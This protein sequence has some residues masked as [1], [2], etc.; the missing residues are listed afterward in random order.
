MAERFLKSL[1]FT[2]TAAQ[3]RVAE[4]LA[5]DMAKDLP[6]L[7]LVQ[8]DVGSGKTLVAARAALDTIDAGYQ[9]AFMAP[10]ELLAEQ[11]HANLSAWLSHWTACGL[12]QRTH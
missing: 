8:G 2:P 5:A 11:H 7:R 6:M 4:E 9:V 1:P 12:A 3:D 10:T